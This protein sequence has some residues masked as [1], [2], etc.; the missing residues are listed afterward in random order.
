[1]VSW[2]PVLV[3]RYDQA[4]GI[5][6]RSCPNICWTKSDEGFVSLW[7]GSQGDQRPDF[8]PFGTLG[9]CGAFNSEIGWQ[10]DAST[11]ADAALIL[12]EQRSGWPKFDL[13]SALCPVRSGANRLPMA[14]SGSRCGS[15]GLSDN[16]TP[17]VIR[18]M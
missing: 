16:L 9:H 7:I 2:N 4:E 12:R 15:S 8:Y 6:G 14:F 17:G 3:Q 11:S 1:M 5:L 18:L 13:L 10:N